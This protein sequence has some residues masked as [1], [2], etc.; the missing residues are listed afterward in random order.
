M[1]S[2]LAIAV[3]AAAQTAT[4]VTPLPIAPP[5]TPPVTEGAAIETA[6]PPA[7]VQQDEPQPVVA[8]P[9]M[10]PVQLQ[11]MTDIDSKTAK[12][13]EMF[14]IKLSGPITIDGKLV[15]EQGIT[16]QGEIVHAAKARAAGKAGELILAARYLDWNG[17]RIPLRTFRYGPEVGESRVAEAM[18]AAVVI[19]APVALLIAGGEMRVPAGTRAIAKVSAD[20]LIPAEPSM[21]QPAAPALV[22]PASAAPPPAGQAQ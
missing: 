16:G 18:G 7:P 1:I 21:A 9:A 15:V 14:P 8:I 13:G 19:A 11:I 6:A 4:P 17:V 20:V 5:P 10:T 22:A 3:A 2:W 12:I